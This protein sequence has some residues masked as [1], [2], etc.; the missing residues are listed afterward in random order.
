MQLA[1][2][3][4]LTAF[5]RDPL[6][7]IVRVV[8]VNLSGVPVTYGVGLYPD[9]DPAFRL[10]SLGASVG[11]G[12]DG[13]RL[14]RIDQT[15]GGQPVTIYEIIASK[16]LLANFPIAGEIGDDIT[17]SHELQVGALPMPFGFAAVET[18][19]FFGTLTIKG[20]VND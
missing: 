7:V 6:H 4:D 12:A 8:G 16:G 15:P 17:F 11:V 10:L 9:A 13:I 14:V 3:L 1:Q 19:L 18:T 2:R 20:S 5:R